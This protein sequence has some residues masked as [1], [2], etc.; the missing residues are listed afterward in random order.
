MLKFVLA[1]RP[2]F[3]TITLVGCFVGLSNNSNETNW[4]IC[5]LG[6]LLAL[7]GH[8][9][10][11]LINDYYDSINGTDAINLDRI[12]PFTGGSRFIQNKKLSQQQIKWASITLFL[13]VILGGVIILIAESSINLIWIG[14]AGLSLGWLYSSPPL[15]LMSKGIWGEVAISS[16]WTLVVIGSFFL[17]HTNFQEKII[18]QGLAYGIGVS[19]ILFINQIP[20]IKADQAV[21]KNTLAVTTAKKNLS[22]VYLIIISA[23]HA[24]I[25]FGYFLGVLANYYLICLIAYPIQ[26]YVSKNLNSAIKN[27]F[28]FEKLIIQTILGAH[29]IGISLCIANVLSN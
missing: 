28:K 24:I 20:D 13:F 10:A 19:S 6:V 8:A 12:S 21:G 29:L 5:I 7:L 25:L 17:N 14:V 4:N 11:N 23:S 3:L 26:F 22:K 9:A 16:V 27:K 2:S 1:T 18:F 15:Q